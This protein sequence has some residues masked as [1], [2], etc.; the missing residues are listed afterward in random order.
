[1]RG[2]DS[3]E[4][5]L[6]GDDAPSLPGLGP[7]VEGHRPGAAARLVSPTAR[8]LLGPHTRKSLR[9]QALSLS[10]KSRTQVEFT[11]MRAG[12]RRARVYS[13]RR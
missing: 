10:K 3:G 11:T 13:C 6:E 2:A 5:L 1:M 12:A 8:S 4:V 9:R 7:E